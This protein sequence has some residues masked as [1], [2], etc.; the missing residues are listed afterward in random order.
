MVKKKH[1]DE[2]EEKNFSDSL[3]LFEVLFQE[4]LK[5]VPDKKSPS[6]G[7]T[8]VQS[9]TPKTLPNQQ[10]RKKAKV[11]QKEQPSVSANKTAVKSEMTT[12]KTTNGQESIDMG[13]DSETGGAKAELK[14]APVIK[15]P[16][17]GKQNTLEMTRKGTQPKPK[18]KDVEE[19]AEIERKIAPKG[20]IL[21]DI[22]RI[23]APASGP[24]VAPVAPDKVGKL[25]LLI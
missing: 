1:P 18:P 20:V 24:T 8:A 16:S 22:N 21:K 14:S 9:A 7:T 3:E 12:P 10:A 6:K 19:N 13:M 5:D 25:Y 4:E 15:A 17:T 23:K 11:N 2:V